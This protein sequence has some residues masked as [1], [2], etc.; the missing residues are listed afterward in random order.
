MTPDWFMDPLAINHKPFA[1]CLLPSRAPLPL[2]L[3]QFLE[4]HV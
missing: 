1:I 4:V 3:F 2:F